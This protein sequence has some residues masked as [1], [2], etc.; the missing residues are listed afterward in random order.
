[1][2]LEII[3]DCLDRSCG[4]NG[5]KVEFL[6]H[7]IKLLEKPGLVNAKEKIGDISTSYIINKKTP[8]NT[9]SLKHGDII[10]FAEKG[11][12]I[13]K[14]CKIRSTNILKIETMRLRLRILIKVERN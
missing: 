12:G 14:T 8:K 10:K 2:L 7:L 5:Y 9:S 1:M 4:V 6:R 3:L 11:Y 13:W